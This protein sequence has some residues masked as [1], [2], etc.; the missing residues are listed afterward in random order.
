[1]DLDAR[2]RAIEPRLNE[3]EL[4][5]TPDSQIT[6]EDLAELQCLVRE[7]VLQSG[8]PT[9]VRQFSLDS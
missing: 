2:A 3:P 1:M 5:E 6:D 4:E 8:C 9:K 7:V